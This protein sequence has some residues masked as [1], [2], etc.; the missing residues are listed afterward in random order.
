VNS[1][2]NVV[3]TVAVALLTIALF[4]LLNQPI[5]EPA[6]PVTIQGFSFSPYQ[7]E[8]NPEKGLQPDDADIE[9][10]LT[11]LRGKTHAVRTYTVQGAMADVPEIAARLGIN[12]ALGA[13]VD[14]N[15]EASSA[16]VDRLIE[17][18]S[19][20]R[21]VVRTI[22][23]NEVLLRNDM[24]PE[25]LIGYL[26]RARKR[27]DV[28]VSTAEPWH[29]WL[30]YPQLAEHVDYLA[31]HMLPYWEGQK[32]DTA[33]DYIVMRYQQLHQRF[34]D[35]PIVIA[36]VG[37]PS[38]GRSKHDA[39]ASQ[40]NEG[41]FLRSF[42]AR[43]EQEHYIY[44]IMEAFDQPWK[45]HAERGVGAYWGV[46]NADR[47]AKFAFNDPIVREPAWPIIALVSIIIATIILA[48]LLANSQTLSS[49]G[50]SFLAIIAFATATGAVWTIH[51]Y[52][53]QYISIGGIFIGILLVIGMLGVI[54]VMLA[55]AHEWAEAN[56][57]SE[58]RRGLQPLLLPDAELPVV[59]IHLPCYNE[60]P[61][62][63]IQTLDALA[64]L[65]YP[66]FE[67]IVIDN[68][69]RDPAIWQ[70]VESHCRKLGE[71][72]RFFHVEPLAGFKAGALNY[73]LEKTAPDAEIIAVIDSD[74]IVDAGWLR[75]LTP[76]FNRPE[77]AIVQAPQDYRDQMESA[78][79]SMCH[80]EYRGFFQI[81]MVI[82]NERNAIIQH[83]TMTMVRRSVLLEVGGWS[84]WCIT[85]DAELGLRIFASGYEADYIATSCGRGLMPDNFVDFRKQRY[86]WA[87]GAIQILRR[88]A[89]ALF[90]F[91]PTRLTPGQRYHFVAGWLPWIADGANM[92][93]TVAAI[94]WSLIMLLA[95]TRFD[96]PALIVSLLPLSL[97]VFKSSK[98]IYLYRTRLNA[99]FMQT[100]A[101]GMAGLALTHTISR[102]II[103][104]FLTTDK[105]FFRTPKMAH[106][107]AWLKALADARE[108]II[109]MIALWLAA[110]ALLYAQV[111][112][113]PD[114]LMWIIV[115]MVQSLPYLAST[116]VALI[117]AMPWLPAI[118]VG[119]E[120]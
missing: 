109:L 37:W 47:Q 84:E 74:Y 93:F 120:H 39:V 119:S 72:F 1:T 117:S 77:I 102:A 2:V 41:I 89:G 35:K 25:Q 95:P 103:D 116:I 62:M 52:T 8:Q 6:W 69:T 83:G 30:K 54:V 20:H 118:P 48:L 66:H 29:I 22:I 12:V 40:A 42:L 81:G 85:E 59:S 3:T 44:Y 65:D 92:L 99:G 13:W 56:W 14:S 111:I 61:E 86:R 21:N 15:R 16:Q 38:Q 55:E 46:Y 50:R 114:I 87:Y 94:Y 100:M 63:M 96:P 97:F 31:V 64:L 19:A 57:V 17:I 51:E 23:G 67:V 27:L 115:L 34:P 107:Q 60:P 28:P 106:A 26:D 9:R 5:S 105:P 33:V 43:A 10:D 58:R 110:A 53:R 70:P 90:G 88:H 4:A 113:S 24:T 45:L 104:G 32:V 101:A 80:A 98:L 79:K 91:S 71:H 7:K 78:F 112:D 82:R 76:Q 108:E 11:L 75:N 73:A 68:N 18:A 36:E 49:R